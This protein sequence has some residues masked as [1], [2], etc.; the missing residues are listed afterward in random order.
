MNIKRINAQINNQKTLQYYMRRMLNFARNVFIFEGLPDFI[1][2]SFMNKILTN[3]GSIA[4]F[5]DEMMGILCLPWTNKG[6]Y[7]VYGRPSKIEVHGEN[8]YIRTLDNT[9]SD[10]NEHFVILYDNEGRYP[11]YTDIIQ[12][13]LRIAL[14]KRTQD[15][16][17]VQ[18]RTM[19]G[20]K[21]N[22]DNEMSVKKV[23]DDI[24]SMCERVLTYDSIDLEDISS[25]LTQVPNISLDMQDLIEAE[26]NEFFQLCGISSVSIQKKER[27]IKDEMI[28]SLGGVI[29]SR[30]NRYS[31]RKKFCQE[32][33][34][35]FGL[36]ISVK[37][38]DGIPEMVSFIGSDKDDKDIIEDESEVLDIV[39]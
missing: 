9:S 22:K 15:I 32:M 20:W 29:A 35:V 17:V 1:D 34:E 8:G 16:N 21:C 12:I 7:D 24:D 38:Y 2:T 19:R 4:F 18:L 14:K 36:D 5:N 11:I 10:V 39:S 25:I 23:L 37:F 31:T 28:A 3:Q 27:M 33:K 6:E 26:W 30:Y 13:A